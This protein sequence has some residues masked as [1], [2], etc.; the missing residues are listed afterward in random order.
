MALTN[1]T[2]NT[3]TLP[4]TAQWAG[5]A[6]GNGN[7]VCVASTSNG[8][9][10]S[11]GGVTWTGVT[12]PSATGAWTNI[13]FDGTT[14]IALDNDGSACTSTNGGVTW[15]ARIALPSGV[16]DTWGAFTYA[17][18]MCLAV[19]ADYQNTLVTTDHGSTW[20]VNTLATSG[21]YN[22]LTWDPVNALWCTLNGVANSQVSTT[23]PDGVTW[24]N[25]AAALPVS[26]AWGAL[27]TDGLGNTIAIGG[28]TAATSQVTNVGALSKDGG[29]TWTSITLPSTAN[30][31]G[32]AYLNGMFM[33]VTDGASPSSAYTTNLGAT[34]TVD[35]TLPAS[36]WA[37]LN[38]VDNLFI[39]T[40]TNSSNANQNILVIWPNPAAANDNLS[41]EGTI[42]SSTSAS[43]TTVPHSLT[44]S[45]T[46][47]V[48]AVGSL[49]PAGSLTALTSQTWNT[50]AL[51]ATAAWANVAYG[52]GSLVC[53]ASTSNGVYSVNG[54]QTWINTTLPAATGAWSNIVFDGVAHIALDNDGSA[55]YSLNG[56]ITWSPRIAL[57]SGVTDTWGGFVYNGSLCLAVSAD[58][59]NVLVTSDHGQT[60]TTHLLATSGHYNG[61][62][63]D[64]VNELWCTVDGTGSSQKASTSPDGITWTDNQ[65]LPVKQTWAALATDNLGNTLAI[66]GAGMNGAA[67][68][69]VGALSKDGGKTWSSITL[70]SSALWC[71]V[72]YLN[73]MFM[74]VTSATPVSSAYT[75]NL[76]TTWT[77]DS[78]YPA[79]D[80]S[81]LNAVDNRFVVTGLNTSN[82]NQAELVIWPDPT[83]TGA[84]AATGTIQASS[85]A[86]LKT[87]STTSYASDT[88]L[89]FD[90]PSVQGWN[91]AAYGNGHMVCIGGT[92]SGAYSADLG[93]T[94]T[95]STLPT[96]TG[97][98]QYIIF[99]GVAHI[100][101]DDNGG[102]CYSLD[103]GVTWSKYIATGAT[104]TWGGIACNNSMTL[105]VSND[106]INTIYT[107]N[108]G[109]SWSLGS[110]KSS[111]HYQGLSWDPVNNLWC[112]IGATANQQKSSTSPDGISWTDHTTLPSL[113]N[114][115]SCATD[116]LGNTIVLGGN[117][118]GGT[119][120]N[121]AALSKD[122]GQTWSALTL[123]STQVWV[124]LAYANSIFMAVSKGATT[125]SVY[126]SNLGTSWTTDSTI[127][128]G[129]PGN[130]SACNGIF[131]SPLMTPSYTDSNL[132]YVWSTDSTVQNAA[133]FNATALLTI[134]TA[135][136]LATVGA[137]TGVSYATIYAYAE[138]NGVLV[139]PGVI[140]EIFQNPFRN[141]YQNPRMIYLYTTTIQDVEEKFATVNKPVP[142]TY[143]FSLFQTETLTGQIDSEPIDEHAINV[144]TSID[145]FPLLQSNFQYFFTHGQYGRFLDS[146]FPWESQKSWMPQITDLVDGDYLVFTRIGGNGIGVFWCTTNCSVQSPAYFPHQV[147]DPL[148]LTATGPVTRG[149]APLGS[150]YYLLRDADANLGPPITV[151]YQDTLNAQ[152]SR[153]R[154]GR[155]M[156]HQM[157]MT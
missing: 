67:A 46:V 108:H 19:S 114:W 37:W 127:G 72:A 61:L 93:Q 133:K 146:F 56:G 152:F 115:S 9:Y 42:Q 45:A 33:I 20:T 80:W 111:D 14:H 22:G 117:D 52:N 116:G 142:D 88:W 74:I 68:T 65:N 126:T 83:T 132:V 124:G 118:L 84:I 75:T 79:G 59:Q 86:T 112:T 44:S 148:T 154:S 5:V 47:Q 13:V 60:Y 128:P 69:S 10:S 135:G 82:A 77:V 7:L 101:V 12:L 62:T 58:Y 91:M 136:S 95:A 55:C 26:Q 144:G 51:P 155:S 139:L 49:T 16:V 147:N 29:V 6:Y 137:M 89:S 48:T 24:T 40:G 3:V 34:W 31:S 39:A 53:V 57:P 11:D 107:T 106:Y 66:G 122:G 97:V 100:V 36:D 150:P 119:A 125:T 2:W 38:A 18:G 105:L 43:L 156:A 104:D 30:W 134:N 96:S 71:G 131:V 17:N 143:S 64:P 78:T 50:V 153:D 151:T 54:G 99:D 157:R 129:F 130:L 113:G 123:P 120:A 109:V 70:P 35:S 15:S 32:I 90:L 1:N 21:H 121:T 98:W 140:R 81:W 73:G 28:A 41:A 8:A 141:Q 94:W 102:S 85:Y 103:G 4:A 92:V 25:H 63:W 110:M 145:S 27:A 138:L 23:S 87:A 76:G 149:M